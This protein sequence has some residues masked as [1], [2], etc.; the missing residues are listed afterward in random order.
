LRKKLIL[1]AAIVMGL[2]TTVAMLAS[3]YP[4]TTTDGTEASTNA[5]STQSFLIMIGFI[6]LL[7]VMMYFLTIRPQR[8]RQQE[9]QKMMQAVQRGD[10]VITIGGLYGTVESVGED[11][12]VIKVESGTTMRFV[13]SAI[14]N[15]VEAPE[16]EAK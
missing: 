8:K 5:N 3:C 2:I 12:I 13:K 10:K 14:A 16:P 1:T 6:V 4:T 9:H 15:K 11:S 7:F